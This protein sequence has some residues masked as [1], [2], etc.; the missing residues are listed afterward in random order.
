MKGYRLVSLSLLSALI[1]AAPGVGQE[2]GSGPAAPPG[3]VPVTPAPYLASR[4]C[5]WTFG[6]FPRRG[7]PDDYCPHLY[8]RQ[9]WP[10]YPP[11]YRC[12]PASDCA[13]GT[14]CDRAADRLTWWFIPTPRALREAVWRQP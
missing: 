8:P 11:F 1:A 5:G 9:C 12:A 10:P 4:G 3:P 7:C 13:A 2:L 6:C 14:G